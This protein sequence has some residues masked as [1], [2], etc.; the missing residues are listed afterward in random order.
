MSGQSTVFE[1]SAN[2]ITWNKH[3]FHAFTSKKR[4]Q[5]RRRS[6]HVPNKEMEKVKELQHWKLFEFRIQRRGRFVWHIF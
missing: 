2:V 1:I 3:T 6:E 4:W 5:H